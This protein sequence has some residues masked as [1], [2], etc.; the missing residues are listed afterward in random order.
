[1]A[2]DEAQVKRAEATQRQTELDV[3]RYTP[4]AQRGSVSQQELDNA[5]R[6]TRPTRPGWG[7]APRRNS[8]ASVA[9]RRAEKALRGRQDADNIAASR[10]ALVDARLNSA[11]PVLSPTPGVAGFRGRISRTGAGPRTA[12]R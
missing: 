2:R 3:N 4:L 6:A 5:S 7:R 12:R 8:Q 10:A 11:T 9:V 1:M